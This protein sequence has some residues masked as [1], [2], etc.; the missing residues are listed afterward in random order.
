MSVLQP[1][2]H[3]P[4]GP[5]AASQPDGG[6]DRGSHKTQTSWAHL[7][8]TWGQFPE[9]DQTPEMGEQC[10]HL[11]VGCTGWQS[12]RGS[13][14]RS[15]SEAPAVCAH[16]GLAGLEGA[17]STSWVVLYSYAHPG[18]APSPMGMMPWAQ[19]VNGAAVGVHL[20]SELPDLGTP[21]D[22]SSTWRSTTGSVSSHPRSVSRAPRMWPPSWVLLPRW[23]ASTSLTRLRPCRVSGPP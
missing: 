18:S 23:G 13:T 6:I 3:S 5:G 4:G 16:V 14:L 15:V 20:R 12:G 19:G 1:A 7:P 22:L 11:P 10:L 9:E 17:L 8:S 2:P 21:L